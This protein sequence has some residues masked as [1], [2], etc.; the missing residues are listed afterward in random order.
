MIT[1]HYSFNPLA[2]FYLF[3]SIAA[4]TGSAL[5]SSPS[6]HHQVLSAWQTTSTGLFN[7]A[8]TLFS[9]H[10]TLHPTDRE[11]RL[12]EAMTLLQLQ[13]KTERLITRSVAL[14]DALI[15][16]NA[17]DEIGLNARYFRGRIEHIHR[18]PADPAAALSHYAQ[19]HHD[20]PTHPLAAQALIKIALIE[21]Y[22]PQPPEALAASFH[23]LTEK[24]HA[25]PPGYGRR[26]L[27]LVLGE[28]SLRLGLGD[29]SARFHFTEALREG[30]SAP[31]LRADVLVRL[32]ELA[33]ILGDTEEARLHY[34]AF[35]DQFPRDS[36][37]LMIS[38]RLS[39]LPHHESR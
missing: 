8:H 21:L 35:L 25:L 9:A 12:G 30:I 29:S 33:R 20:H 38:Q 37:R 10:S 17:H 39:N 23:T 4:L 16:E 7:D 34:Q 19:L 6:V 1:P 11:T 5:F 2:S 15:K 28:A 26:D 22:Q 36:R 24:A 13:P 27:H 3:A 14:L 31:T 18:T 32:G